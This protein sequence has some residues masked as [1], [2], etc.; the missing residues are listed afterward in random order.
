MRGAW[1]GGAGAGRGWTKWTSIRP[2]VTVTGGAGS[3]SA[4]PIGRPGRRSIVAAG[5][6]SSVDGSS[7]GGCV[8]RIA[9][10]GTGAPGDGAGST[11]A[12]GVDAG[13]GCNGATGSRL[14]GTAAASGR[15]GAGSEAGTVPEPGSDR[16]V[17]D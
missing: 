11:I 1:G 3:S 6:G 14:V 12:R 17:A 16:A 7:G 8:E 4:V 10:I 13:V 9:V 2:T 15:A 5:D